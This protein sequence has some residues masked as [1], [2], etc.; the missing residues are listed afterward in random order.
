MQVSCDLTDKQVAFLQKIVKSENQFENIKTIEEAVRECINM[1]MFEAGET[2]AEQ[3][4][5]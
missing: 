5:M 3:E 1:A 2:T 4:G